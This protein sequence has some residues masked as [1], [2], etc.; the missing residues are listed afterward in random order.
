MGKIDVHGHLYPRDYWKELLKISERKSLPVDVQRIFTYYSK[1]GV[2]ITPE[3]SADVAFKAGI[4]TQLLPLSIPSVYMTDGEMSR[5]LA[6][7]ANDTCAEIR[8]K[9]P[10]KF[11]VMASVP[12]NAFKSSDPHGDARTAREPARVT[13]R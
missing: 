11:L 5:E 8:R 12:L 2:L 3:E 13:V 4:E 1:K 7:M 9:F 10:G 6:Q